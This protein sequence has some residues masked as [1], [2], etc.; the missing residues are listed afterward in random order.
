ML[1]RSRRC[2]AAAEMHERNV[3]IDRPGRTLDADL[4]AAVL[5]RTA[6]RFR[7]NARSYGS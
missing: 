1:L 3:R 2:F 5:A 6:A 4:D 7:P